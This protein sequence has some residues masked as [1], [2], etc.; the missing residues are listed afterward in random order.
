[1]KSNHW[2]RLAKGL[3]FTELGMGTA[4][5]GN[6]YKAITEDE[7][8]RGRWKK[9]WE[10][11]CR[12]FDTAPLY[13]LGLAETRVNRFLKGKPR[14]E[15]VLSTKNRT[16]DGGFAKP[17]R[18]APALASFFDTPTRPRDVSTIP[19]VNPPHFFMGSVI[20]LHA[21]CFSFMAG[22]IPPMAMLGRSLL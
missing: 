22:V 10:V 2:K 14:D 21:A 6:L 19:M 5:L 18:N 1:M 8:K 17:K 7:A 20:G 13:G 15:Y 11:G 9:A 4:P 12:Y 3:T 16:I